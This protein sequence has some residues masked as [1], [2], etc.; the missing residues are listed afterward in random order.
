MKR[1]PNVS[2]SSFKIL[3]LADLSAPVTSLDI[4]CCSGFSGLQMR[5]LCV[6]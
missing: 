6:A 5:A 3:E 1:P 4:K 2:F